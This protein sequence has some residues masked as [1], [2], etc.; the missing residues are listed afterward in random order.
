[1]PCGSGVAA[2]ACRGPNGVY[3]VVVPG[4]R[5]M[6]GLVCTRLPAPR[7]HRRGVAAVVSV[8]AVLACGD[9]I[10]CAPAFAQQQLQ[11]F[12]FPPSAPPRPK[13][14][15]AIERDKA[16]E[17]QQMLVKANEIDYDYANHRVSAVG[18]VQM[19]YRNST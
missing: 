2:C 7:P 15:I 14:K 17:Q 12:N 13:S 9:I 16:G 4:G 3:C 5:V 8:L 1:A 18:N 6:T 11:L 10:T 19:Y